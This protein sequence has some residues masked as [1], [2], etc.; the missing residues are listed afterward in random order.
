MASLRLRRMDGSTESVELSRSQPVTIGRQSFNDICVE[1]H[2]VAPMLCRVSWNKT[3]FEVTA[4]T[5]SGVEVNS[6]TVVHMLLQPGDTIHVGSCDLVFVDESGTGSEPDS[7]RSRKP[8]SKR[9]PAPKPESAKQGHTRRAHEEAREEKPADDLSLFMGT[10]LTESQ[11]EMPPQGADDDLFETKPRSHPKSKIGGAG[12][13]LRPVRPG[14]Q[15][16]LKSPLVLTLAGGGL[17]LLLIT[18]IFWFLLSREQSNR[19]YDRA[20]A[21]MNAGQ[22]SQSIA[23]FEKFLQ[24]YPTHGLR[25]QA[26]RGLG[27]ALIQKEISGAIP[28]WKRGLERLNELIKAHRNES[29]FSDLHLSLF[30]FAE[31]ISLGAAKTA[32]TT[33]DPELLVIS[34][35]AQ[36][37]LERYADPSAPPTGTINR[38]VEQRGKAKGAIEKQK[39]F[40]LAMTAVDAALAEK[41]PMLALSERERLVKSFPEFVSSKRVKDV[42]QKALDLER[43]VVATDET[44]RPA[45]TG[46]STPPPPEPILGLFHTRSR[47]EDS[48]AGQIVFV[49]G[50]DSCYAVD[51][52]T[53][54]VV[55]RRVIGAWSPFFPVKAAGSQAGIDCLPAGDRTSDL[56]SVAGSTSLGKSARQRWSDLSSAGG[57]CTGSN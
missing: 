28:A 53:G 21:E 46:E 50:K 1:E 44:E 34:K 4:A 18:G 55:W 51:P 39:T 24:E 45:E 37:L 11:A 19:L 13:G 15:E 33:R 16:I 43:S 36:D 3:G 6:N 49:T 48:S 17:A 12:L 35:D 20:V 9:E 56:E 47:T 57:K 38:I 5:A 32:E 27:K 8:G 40:D 22:Y 7:H 10:V 26:D 29:D 2:D 25:R 42:L 54:E 30:Q 14:E 23:T 31:Q 52:A 41:K